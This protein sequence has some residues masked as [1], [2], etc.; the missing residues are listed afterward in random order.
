[1]QLS[2][3]AVMMKLYSS[4]YFGLSPAVVGKNGGMLNVPFELPG[5]AM[6]M[7]LP[8]NNPVHGDGAGA[9]KRVNWEKAAGIHWLI[10]PLRSY[11]ME[12]TLMPV[13]TYIIDSPDVS[14]ASMKGR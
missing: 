9:F 14:F 3:W 7:V 5:K 1:M 6:F 13:P 4:P 2:T 10:V 11:G 12:V 8:K